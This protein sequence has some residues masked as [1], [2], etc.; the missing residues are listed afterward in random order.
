MQVIMGEDE[1]TVDL[2]NMIR[3]DDL[4]HAGWDEATINLVAKLEAETKG[5]ETQNN[6][7]KEKMIKEKTT[8]NTKDFS[9]LPKS[10]N[11]KQ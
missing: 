2:I 11:Y 5:E 3:F 4:F 9:P 10:H 1:A 6:K 7:E 8:K